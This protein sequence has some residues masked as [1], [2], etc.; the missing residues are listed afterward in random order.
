[1]A[2]AYGVA[3]ARVGVESVAL[4]VGQLAVVAGAVGRGDDDVEVLKSVVGQAVVHIVAIP[5]YYGLVALR[6]MFAHAQVGGLFD[7]H[8]VHHHEVA[9][10]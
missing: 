5:R 9:H 1:M 10:Q 8:V 3:H 6:G 2:Y 4:V 7:M